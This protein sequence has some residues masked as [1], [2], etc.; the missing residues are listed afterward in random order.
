MTTS[1]DGESS[2]RKVEYA[3]LV[4]SVI[5]E[6][7][8]RVQLRVTAALGLATIFITQLPLEALRRLP[9]FYRLVTVAGIVLLALAAVALFYYTH[10]LNR[11]R[12]KI[13]SRF[14]RAPGPDVAKYWVDDFGSET[15]EPYI[16]LYNLGQWLLAAGGLAFAVVIAKLL[17]P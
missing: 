17:L 15:H 7:I 4:L 10:R 1:I 9:L 13:A 6:D 12:I 11:V 2:T 5:N 14:V 16:W 8:G 3:N